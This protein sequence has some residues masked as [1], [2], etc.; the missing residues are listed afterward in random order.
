MQWPY[1]RFTVRWIM[2]FV[3]F[4]ALG[5]AAMRDPITHWGPREVTTLA[6]SVLLATNILAWFQRARWQV[7][8]IGFGLSGWTYLTLSLGSPLAEHLP[9][10][11]SN[12]KASR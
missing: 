3:S 12:S 7:F 5:L 10:A 1:M 8:W 9:T 2:A 11:A 6:L 4:L